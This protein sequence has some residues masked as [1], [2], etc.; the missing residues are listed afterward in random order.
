MQKIRVLGI[1]LAV[2][3]IALL[4]GCVGVPGDPAY[5]GGYAGGYSG[6]GYVQ[7]PY[8][9]DPSPVVVAPA[10]IYIQGGGYYDG[11]R[12]P[13]YD[14]GRPYYNRPGYPYP[15]GVRPGYPGVRPGYPNAG[16]RPGVLPRPGIQQP[17]RPGG[18]PATGRP[19]LPN[20]PGTPINRTTN[21]T[22]DP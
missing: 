2:G 3:G 7:Q 13:Y 17:I 22:R 20:V 12:R 15:G 14:G 8:Y 18:L 19:A 4:T 16:V 21:P 1:S 10:P 11:G 9:A 6:G 5:G